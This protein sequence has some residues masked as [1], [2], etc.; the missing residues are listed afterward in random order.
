MK[1]KKIFSLKREEREMSRRLLNHADRKEFYL[2]LASGESFEAIKPWA[3]A[4]IEEY[5]AEI[6]IDADVLEALTVC[7]ESKLPELGI[8]EQ[9]LQVSKAS[10]YKTYERQIALILPMF[11]IKKYPMYE[12][13][14]YKIAFHFLWDLAKKARLFNGNMLEYIF[15]GGYFSVTSGILLAKNADILRP[16][17]SVC[18]MKLNTMLMALAQKE[19]IISESSEDIAEN[20]FEKSLHRPLSKEEVSIMVVYSLMQIYSWEQIDSHKRPSATANTKSIEAAIA[21]C[22]ANGFSDLEKWQQALTLCEERSIWN[23]Q[24][25]L[26]TRY[27]LRIKLYEYSDLKKITYSFILKSFQRGFINSEVIDFIFDGRTFSNASTVVLAMSS[28][29]LKENNLSGYIQERLLEMIVSLIEQTQ[30]EA[31]PDSVVEK[32]FLA[33]IERVLTKEEIAI[34]NAYT[35]LQAFN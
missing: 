23:R 21:Y 33:S 27:L 10:L 24:V 5:E 16:I 15:F 9:A 22:E 17:S 12:K 8:L 31:N 29:K 2:R 14:F 28:K 11:Y 6:D 3:E 34:V 4:K 7:G 13:E 26:I 19:G 25:A 18:R 32:L 20:I 30:L 35:L 1:K